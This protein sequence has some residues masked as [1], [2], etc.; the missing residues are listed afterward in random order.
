MTPTA[1]IE[2]LTA[3]TSLLDSKQQEVT[4]AKA[5]Y[6]TGLVKLSD[7]AQQVAEMQVELTALKPSLEQTV[8]EVEQL[9]AAVDKEKA[10]VVEPKKAAVDQEVQVAD[11]AAQDARV[12]DPVDSAQR[13]LWSLLKQV[14]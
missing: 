8:G 2:L 13:I 4:R 1:Y 11:A 14:F 5:R 12:C 10:E 7:T 3:F 6:E 9:V